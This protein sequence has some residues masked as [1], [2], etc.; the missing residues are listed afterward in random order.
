MHARVRQ[1][2]RWVRC[3]RPGAGSGPRGQSD[4]DCFASGLYADACEVE[5]IEL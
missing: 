5:F 2:R 3:V 4:G 1:A